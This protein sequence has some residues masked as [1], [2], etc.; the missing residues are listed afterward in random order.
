MDAAKKSKVD[1][2]K[3]GPSTMTDSSSDDNVP[4][5]VRRKEA[6][7]HKSSNEGKEAKASSTDEARKV[8]KGKDVAKSSTDE[9]NKVPKGKGVVKSSTDEAKKV[10]KGKGVVKSSTDE[11]KK[12]PKGKASD[13]ADKNSEKAD[14]DDDQQSEGDLQLSPSE[15]T[16]GFI[17]TRRRRAMKVTKFILFSNVLTLR[18]EKLV[19]GILQLSRYKSVRMSSF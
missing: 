5:S 9:A 6:K 12:V 19:Q 16:Q 4:L 7:G 18:N 2:A 13:E 17:L 15:A 8:P 14:D 3:P 1:D 10:P 11:A